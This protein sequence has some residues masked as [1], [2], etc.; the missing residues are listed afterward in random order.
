MPQLIVYTA[1]RLTLGC[2]FS[3]ML[4]VKI[5]NQSMNDFILNPVCLPF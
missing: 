2:C 4:A 5:R 3:P 1:Q